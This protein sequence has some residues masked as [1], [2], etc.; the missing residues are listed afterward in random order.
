MK[1]LEKVLDPKRCETTMH[2]ESFKADTG[3]IWCP[4]CNEYGKKIAR[5]NMAVAVGIG[6]AL[7]LFVTLLLTYCC[8]WEAVVGKAAEVKNASATTKKNSG[9]KWIRSPL[10]MAEKMKKRKRKTPA[11]PKS[12]TTAATTSSA[13]AGAKSSTPPPPPSTTTST[14]KTE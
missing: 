11:T 6:A 1:D 10:Y 14:V 12:S 2:T 3:D 7:F 9:G 13:A 4:S 5:R 8:C